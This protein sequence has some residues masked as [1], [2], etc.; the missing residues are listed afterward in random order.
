MGCREIAGG[1]VFQ[2]IA[3]ERLSRMEDEISTLG[4]K[5]DLDM[6]RKV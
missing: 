5:I 1:T 6:I 2:F 3:N 4:P